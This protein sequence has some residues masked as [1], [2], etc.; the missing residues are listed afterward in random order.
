M[1]NSHDHSYKHLF[2]NPEVVVDLLQGFVHEP[3]V[4]EVN[5]STLEKVKD[6]CITD[7][8]RERIDDVIWRVQHKKRWNSATQLSDLIIDLP[9]GLERYKPSFEYLILDEGSYHKA[10]LEPL[11]NLVAA[12][13]RLENAATREDIIGV[14]DN[15]LQWL[16]SPEQEMVRRSFSI[17]LNRILLPNKN[18]NNAIQQVN[19]L[20]EIRT[21]LAQTVSTMVEPWLQQGREEGRE[22]GRAEGLN[23]E[24]ALLLRLIRKRFNDATVFKV[25][26]VITAIQSVDTLEIIGDWVI[27]CK[28]STQ[29]LRQMV[30]LHS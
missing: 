4:D 26:P 12:I 27:D 14:M 29:F 2:S 21:M 16:Q 8:L 6:N 25:Q 23:N 22:E 5:F 9:G 3:W 19:D 15:L 1:H 7:D 17:W 28:N 10:Q 13:F 20:M 18:V 24:K 30:S 11:H